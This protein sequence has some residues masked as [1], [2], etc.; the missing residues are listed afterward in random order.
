MI[1]DVMSMLEGTAAA[2]YLR[3]SV[4]AYPL[5]NAGHILGV[6]LVVGSAVPLN[7]RFAGVWKS[8]SMRPLQIVLN[9]TF[10]AGAAI[11]VISGFLLFMPRA[12][13]YIRSGIFLAK[14]GFLALGILLTVLT[15]VAHATGHVRGGTRDSSGD[16]SSETSIDSSKDGKLPVLVRIMAGCSI[17]VWITTLVLGRLI[18]YF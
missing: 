7:L 2:V 1:S 3:G 18:G 9:R 12:T 13:A 14:M 17:A 10:D 8:V 4:W 11:A 6:A 5:V 15:R 16:A